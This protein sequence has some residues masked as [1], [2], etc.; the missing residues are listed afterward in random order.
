LAEKYALRRWM[1]TFDRLEEIAI[2]AH[3]DIFG[4]CDCYCMYLALIGIVSQLDEFKVSMK[5]ESQVISHKT[6]KKPTVLLSHD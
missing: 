2:W 6:A 3:L 5:D 4:L 1:Q